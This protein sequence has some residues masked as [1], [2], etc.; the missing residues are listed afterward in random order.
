MTQEKEKEKVKPGHQED[1]SPIEEEPKL[2]PEGDG[3]S[4][5]DDLSN[6]AKKIKEDLERYRERSREKFSETSGED[7]QPRQQYK[8]QGGQ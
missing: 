1:N 4:S 7:V 3:E 2:S 8:Q 5:A 6:E